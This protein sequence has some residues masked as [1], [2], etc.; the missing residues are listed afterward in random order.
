MTF[1]AE[2]SAALAAPLAR[3]VV[4]TRAQSGQTLSYI[5]GW[6]AIAEANRIFGFDG[7]TRETI[8]LDCVHTGQSERGN[9]VCTYVAKVRV[10]VGG[11]VREGTGAGHGN[12]KQPGQAH[13]KA[14]KEA[15][16]D[17]MKRALMT[18]GNPFG[19]ALYDKMQEG[20]EDAAPAPAPAPRPAAPPVAFSP[21][22][23]IVPQTPDNKPDWK[24]WAE[25]FRAQIKAAPD[26]A[27]L[28]A[29][30]AANLTP[31]LNLKREADKTHDFLTKC[32]NARF[33][34]AA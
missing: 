22:A 25:A 29:L 14:V 15:E 1:T 19:L 33:P 8:R 12:D 11:I 34:T 18:F 27:A 23:I 9:A 13:E 32:A 16:T 24:A 26:R 20:V 17:A 5:E 3:D 10:T 28:D 21:D 6:W 2:Q 4:K 31:L 7:W 30:F